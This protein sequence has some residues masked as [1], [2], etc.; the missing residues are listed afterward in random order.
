MMHSKNKS[1]TQINPRVVATHA[2]LQVIQDGRSLTAAL[3]EK[4]M[5]HP[6]ASF[7]KALCFGVCRWHFRLSL[8]ADGLLE[9]PLR[10]KDQDI[11]L[12]VL[13]GIYQILYLRV[14]THAAVRE[15]VEAAKMLKKSW[16]TGFVNGVLRAFLREQATYVAK[17]DD[18][19]VGRYA[20]PPWL[21]EAILAAWPAQ[22]TA[23]LEANNQHP[24]LSLR[25]NT[26][27]TTTE[28]YLHTLATAGIP[29]KCVADM[30]WAVILED[31]QAVPSLPGFEAGL[32]S[33]QDLAAQHAAPL[34]Q[35]A[36]GLRVLD[37]CAAPGGKTTHILE[38]E[39]RLAA[40]VILDKDPTRMIRIKENI[41]RLQLAPA[42]LHLEYQAADAADTD[43]WW[44]GQP[45]DRI[46]LDAPCSSTG[47][48]RR[49][50][51]IKL[52]RQPEDITALAQ[53]QKTLLHALWPLLKV[54]GILLYATCSIFPE[55]N[56]EGI[57]AFLSTQSDA[58]EDPISGPW[59]IAAHPGRQILTGEQNQ[60]GFY[61]ARLVKM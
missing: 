35:L 14:P 43:S 48:I 27:K 24:P 7:I 38:T 58:A 4:E 55:E 57:A 13:Q 8:L 6:Q 16:A 20:H 3:A 37:A 15:T 12:L 21:T 54:G 26:Q 28:A 23:I 9:K 60:D 56:A 61:Y 47:V 50:P 51:D 31:A 18:T 46:L 5:Q 53:Q 17:A 39:P 45:F 11:Y 34:L 25:V 32:F 52:L 49:H 2:L 41:Q 29:A 10:A 33:V 42:P 40:L 59:G 30:P 19:L 44:D 36:P 22:A 1:H